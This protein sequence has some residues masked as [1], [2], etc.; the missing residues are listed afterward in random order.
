[1]GCGAQLKFNKTNKIFDNDQFL[2]ISQINSKNKNLI[3]F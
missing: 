3:F 2:K 1:M